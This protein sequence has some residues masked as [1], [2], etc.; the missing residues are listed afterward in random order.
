MNPILLRDDDPNAT[1][2]PARLARAYAPLLDAGLPI[3]FS[4]IPSVALDTRAPDGVRE[5]FLEEG[6]PDSPEERPLTPETPLVR[7]L[8]A[9]EGL[10]DV[11]AHGLSHRRIAGGTEFGAI[12]SDVARRRLD[13]GARI[14]QSAL[15]RVPTGF[16]APW[17]ALSRGSV[18]ALSERFE[19]V[20]TGWVDRSLLPMSSWPSHMVDRLTRREALR[21]RESW[22][23]RHRGGKITAEM[24]PADVPAMVDRLCNGAEVG[25][26]VLHHWMFWADET[27]HPVIRALASALK[28]RRVVTLKD[29]GRHLSTMP[30][31][32]PFAAVSAPVTG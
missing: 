10:V 4:V 28:G 15:G 6:S 23:L 26:I 9:N 16:V 3:N 18:E 2:D 13:E 8:R 27:P 22:F 14:F 17:D 19:V 25:V 11:F 12:S 32:R 21:V 31:W 7:W 1:T 29:A 24:S 5:R 30:S 20:S